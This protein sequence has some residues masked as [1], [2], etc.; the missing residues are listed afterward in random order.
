M[1]EVHGV[2]DATNTWMETSL[3]L[4]GVMKG[5]GLSPFLCFFQTL[6]ALGVWV[7]E[8]FKP[9]KQDTKGN[10]SA[11]GVDAVDTAVTDAE[12]LRSRNRRIQKTLWKW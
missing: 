8:F 6:G 3:L 1:G 7:S 9:L 4:F 11:M 10:G 12:I 2:I 5:N